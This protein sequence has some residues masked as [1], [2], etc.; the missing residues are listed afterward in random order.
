VATI[1]LNDEHLLILDS[2]D[3]EFDRVTAGLDADARRH[4]IVS[5]RDQLSDSDFDAQ[6]T[7]LHYICES[8]MYAV[9]YMN[10]T[11]SQWIICSSRSNTLSLAGR[12]G[13]CTMSLTCRLAHVAHTFTV[14][15]LLPGVITRRRCFSS[16][17]I[18]LATLASADA[19]VDPSKSGVR[20]RGPPSA[21]G[22]AVRLPVPS[23]CTNS[24][25]MGGSAS[26]QPSPLRR[27]SRRR[28]KSR[29]M[30]LPFVGSGD[31]D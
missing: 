27:E 7:L 10:I 28:S 19:G 9:G 16:K 29:R 31:D 24:C 12:S 2:Q 15:A 17:R 5:D 11:C 3:T 22:W 13:D 26:A 8:P 21:S 14:L 18:S 20:T 25:K 30:S 1:S 4:I 6:T 23:S